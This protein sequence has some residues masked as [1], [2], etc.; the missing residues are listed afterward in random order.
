VGDG[1]A[2][3]R[4][5]KEAAKYSSADGA[6]ETLCVCSPRDSQCGKADARGADKRN[7]RLVH[8]FSSSD[9]PGADPG[10]E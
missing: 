6:A 2:Y 8:V 7:Q 4:A 9:R 3:D 1:A 5:R 10:S